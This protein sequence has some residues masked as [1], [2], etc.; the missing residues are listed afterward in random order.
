MFHTETENSP[1]LVQDW[2]IFKN[3]KNAGFSI[4]NIGRF[5]QKAQKQFWWAIPAS[6][7]QIQFLQVM[8][9][10]KTWWR[11]PSWSILV[12]HDLICQIWYRTY[13]RY[14][15]S[16]PLTYRQNKKPSVNSEKKN[17]SVFTKYLCIFSPSGDYSR[18]K[19]DPLKW[20]ERRS[21]DFA[22]RKC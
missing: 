17:S 16:S 8:S 2:L 14:H 15:G 10:Q 19:K 18:N 7:L 20:G 21:T 5:L 9:T 6:L 22:I 13:K 1:N 11:L 12:R 4:F 3:K